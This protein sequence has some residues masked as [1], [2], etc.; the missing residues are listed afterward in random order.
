MSSLNKYQRELINQ[1]QGGFPLTRQ[2]Y[3]CVAASLGVGEVNLFKTLKWLLD[4][5]YLSRFGP[6]YNA[7]KIGGEVTLAAL[8][9]DEKNVDKVAEM[10]NRHQQVAHNYRRD[11]KLNMWFVISAEHKGEIEKIIAEIESESGLKV[12]NFPREKAFYLGL[13]LYL[14]EDGCVDTVS[15]PQENNFLDDVCLDEQDRKIISATQSGFPLL[16]NPWQYLSE[17]LNLPEDEILQR[18]QKMQDSGVIR[19]IGAI[20]NHYRLGLKANGMSVWNIADDKAIE[21]GKKVAALDFV[22][23]CYL[24]PRYED[25]WSYNLFAMVHGNNKEVALQKA[26]KIKKLLG[27]DYQGG[28]VLFSSAILKKTGFRRVA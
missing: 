21:L 13:F 23:H 5:G 6:L 24:R 9:V 15:M 3:S 8:S 2:P 12:Y 11:H 26:E 20:P 27:N 19:R 22:S 28:E 4:E 7:E 10:V 17:Q 14:H 16:S 25:V 1:F 18:L